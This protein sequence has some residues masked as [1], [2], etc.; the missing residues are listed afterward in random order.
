M[1]CFIIGVMVGFEVVFLKLFYWSCYSGFGMFH[2]GWL[3]MVLIWGLIE[4]VQQWPLLYLLITI[5]HSNMIKIDNHF[6]IFLSVTF[7]IHVNQTIFNE[8]IWI[9]SIVNYL[10]NI[11]TLTNLKEAWNFENKFENWKSNLKTNLNLKSNLKT[12][13]IMLYLFIIIIFFE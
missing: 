7:C 4:H 13:T 1:N 6:V 3:K 5:E 12:M 10:F 11:S 9:L 2:F 8:Y